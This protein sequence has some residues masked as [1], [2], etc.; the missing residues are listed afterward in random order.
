[1]R[2]TTKAGVPKVHSLVNPTLLSDS[3]RFEFQPKNKTVTFRMSEK[4]LE[5][6][7]KHA[8]S[9]GI[10]YQKYIR[11]VLERQIQRS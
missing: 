9:R 3:I 8:Q 5:A 10:T 2:P 7:K 6:V 4:L 1:M 11:L